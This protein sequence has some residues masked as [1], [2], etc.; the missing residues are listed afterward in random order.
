VKKAF[1]V[2]NLKSLVP[3][4]DGRAVENIK[5]Q[6]NAP[7]ANPTIN[8]LIQFRVPLPVD[9]LF[10]PRLLCTVHDYIFKGFNQPLLG[11]F[12]IPVGD[13][14]D[15]LTEERERETAAIEKTVSELDKIIKGEGA[16]SYNIQENVLDTFED[17]S[18]RRLT[19]IVEETKS[20]S[21]TVKSSGSQK[22]NSNVKVAD[23]E[24]KQ[25]LLLGNEEYSYYEESKSDVLTILSSPRVN[26]RSLT[27]AAGGSAAQRRKTM[28]NPLKAVGLK[29]DKFASGKKAELLKQ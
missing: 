29:V 11:S 4:D 21:S 5:T 3:P 20:R 28:N 1:I 27:L 13:L 2:F 15:K 12:I 19:M 22:R 8:T 18:N 17:H 9:K 25:P 10:Q 14:I 23:D 7:G 16:I 6:P 24:M 26:A